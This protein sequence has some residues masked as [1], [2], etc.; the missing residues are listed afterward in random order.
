M[1]AAGAEVVS[2][3]IGGKTFQAGRRTADHLK[4]TFA[5]FEKAYP[6][7]HLEIA[8][9]CYHTG[10]AA[11]A[12][13][14]DKDGVIDFYVTGLDWW[15]TQR[16]LRSKGWGCWYRHT[17]SWANSSQWHIHG[18]SLGC[19]GPLG[20]YVPG[21]I[22][23]YYNHAFGLV[24]QHT[25]GS[26]TSWFPPNIASSIFRWP[27]VVW[28]ASPNFVTMRDAAIEAMKANHKGS[29]KYVAAAAVRNIVRPW[30]R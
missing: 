10:V 12:G 20:I 30:S 3:T 4:A 28:R 1:T 5:A 16:F 29:P 18:I 25:K 23:D 2:I 6:H 26:D 14:H 13:T 27:V 7:A 22:A 24:G 11:S 9:G 8:Q 21:Q 19:P 15:A 17:G